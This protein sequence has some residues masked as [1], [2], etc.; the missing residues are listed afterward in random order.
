MTE[1]RQYPDIS[2]LAEAMADYIV[3]RCKSAIQENNQF[4]LVLT[5]GSTPRSLYSLLAT[6]A[7]A[8][9]IDWSR[10]HVFWGDERCV[11]L[12]H[13][14]SNFRLAQET[15]LDH[16]PIPAENIYPMNGEIDPAQAAAEYE[17]Q[18]R[19]FFGKNADPIFDLLLLG[20]GEDGHTASLFPE[21]AAIHEEA[22]WA[23]AHH[24][25]KLGAWRLTLTPVVIN[26]A[27]HVA[28]IVA[29]ANKAE[30]LKHVVS[31]PYL[32]FDYPSQIVKPLS[33]HLIWFIDQAAGHLL[34]EG[35][36]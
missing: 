10:V 21:T 27:E 20:M 9:Q 12:D 19:M 22:R 35:L 3:A 13:P 5:G 17:H 33:G 26:E 30:A 1:I 14:D 6:E 15:L 32:P 29:G 24:V 4:T 7:Y 11:P 16:V 36:E 23:I 25:D 2:H 34:A 18:L 8:E 28:F 31:G